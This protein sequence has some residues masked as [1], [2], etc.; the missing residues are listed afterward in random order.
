VLFERIVMKAKLA[1]EPELFAAASPLDQVRAD[2]PPFLIIHGDR[3]TLAPVEDARD[4]ARRLQ[5]VSTS[6]VRYAELHGAQHA[7]DV[8]P[9]I[10]CNAAIAGVDRFLTH[11]YEHNRAELGEPEALAFD[12]TTPVT[13]SSVQI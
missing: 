12:G 1:D 7:F 8:F 2:A 5:A 9:S 13:V 6:D 3:D 11:C 4:F 10:R